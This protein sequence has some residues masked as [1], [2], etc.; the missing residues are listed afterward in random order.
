[1][2]SPDTAKA[3]GLGDGWPVWLP[4]L[5]AGTIAVILRLVYVVD[6]QN[7]IAFTLP[8]M[9]ES[10]HDLWA[11]GRL[12]FLHEGVPYFR[13]PLYIWFLQGIYAL[14]DGYLLPR[15]A[16]AMLGAVTVAFVAD[17]GRRMAGNLAGLIGGLL[18]A[19]TWT[20]IYFA[21]ELLIVTLFVALVVAALWAFVVAMQSD[22]PWIV[23]VGA[24]LLGVAS[25]ARP[26]VLTFLPAL[27]LLAYVTWPRAG[28]SRL[29]AQRTRVLLIALCLAMLPGLALT[30]RN[31][32]VG[33][34]WVFIASQGGVNFYIGNNPDSDGQRAVVPG[35]R[36]T[37]LGGYEDT[38]LRAQEAAGRELKPSEVS[39]YYYGEGL[40]YLANEP[41]DALALYGTKLRKL[42]GAAERPNNKNLHFWRAQSEILRGP[43]WPS[44]A[45]LLALG[46]VGIFLVRRQAVAVP[47]W[48]FLA[49]YAV[50]LL[51][52]FLNER[53]RM[54][55]TTVLAAFAGI[56]V[57]RMVVAARARQWTQG[58][59]ILLAVVALWGASSADRLDFH[60]DRVDVDAFSR[61]TLGN[62]YLRKGDAEAA[63]SEY[64]TA[65]DISRRFPL[66][67]FDEVGVM[68]RKSMVRALYKLGEIDAAKQHLDRLAD[69][70]DGDPEVDLLVG[71]YHVRRHE[72][73]LARPILRRL[74]DGGYHTPELFIN[75]AWVQV[76]GGSPPAAEK[77][78]QRALELAPGSAEALAGLAVVEFDGRKNAE[79]AKRIA[80]NALKLDWNT[81][82][83]HQVLMYYALGKGDTP[84]A[85]YHGRE[86]VRLDPYNMR[87]KRVLNRMGVPH[88]H[89]EGTERPA[90]FQ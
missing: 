17:L 33:D 12:G 39:R 61:A 44:F 73:E 41:G 20:S 88:A 87:V 70:R 3:S 71:M 6:F 29:S 52:F 8:I 26:T 53:F 34:D 64:Q 32:V 48:S 14:N 38:I 1:V 16:Q 42:F 37:W 43:L 51:L 9:D 80:T 79:E 4:A 28:I 2:N 13:A 76:E 66:K 60:N 56:P 19:F 40:R 45:T 49:L 77:S 90:E 7:S 84:M 69:E 55:I 65:L 75:L 46:L 24:G 25:I 59:V 74:R 47:L 86:V 36:G 22:R 5:V 23:W 82:R 68:V 31:K 63:L 85:I 18:L 62:M 81:A 50:G 54:P 15:I 89:P 35:T 78:F 58:A 67:H 11:R 27:V 57:A 10:I 30:V 21:G 83:A 72:F